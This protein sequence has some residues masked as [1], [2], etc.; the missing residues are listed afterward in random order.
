MHI[1]DLIHDN[2]RILSRN[3]DSNQLD[4]INKASILDE[5]QFFSKT[6]RVSKINYTI[7]STLNF[8]DFIVQFLG[9]LL[10]NKKIVIPHNSK[11]DTL[12][13]IN[14]LFSTEKSELVNE[15]YPEDSIHLSHPIF[16]STSG[17]TNTPKLIK[18]VYI[19]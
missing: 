17:S 4:E 18:K 1:N 15:S 16:L 8:K 13:E 7:I 3:N 5:A 12:L 6:L 19:T 2:F 10:A 11:Q 9:S 14:N